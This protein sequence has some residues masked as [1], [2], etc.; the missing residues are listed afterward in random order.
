[1]GE[2]VQTAGKLGV[3]SLCVTLCRRHHILQP[4]ATLQLIRIVLEGSHLILT[5]LVMIAE[6]SHVQFLLASWR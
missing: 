1:M 4:T 3:T 2:M 5:L 6:L